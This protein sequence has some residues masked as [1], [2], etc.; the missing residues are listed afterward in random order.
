MRDV[1]V[2][3]AA[4]IVKRL[5]GECMIFLIRFDGKRLLGLPSYLGSWRNYI[6]KDS[7][8]QLK[9]GL[10][11]D[12]HPLSYSITIVHKDVMVENMANHSIT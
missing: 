2:D 12:F 10:N 1:R 7:Q 11:W 9:T 4:K 6:A 5:S 8:S 3:R